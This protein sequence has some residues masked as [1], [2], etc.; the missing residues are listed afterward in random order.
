MEEILLLL[1]SNSVLCN[2]FSKLY[3]LYQ[4]QVDK[5]FKR[6]KVCENIIP[7]NAGM[8]ELADAS[9]LKSDD[10]SVVWVRV[11]FPAQS[12]KIKIFQI[13]TK[14]NWRKLSNTAK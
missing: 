2:R 10:H 4:K 11:P 6:N 7:Q 14:K 5:F 13:W 1:D 8:A 9:D 3:I 12:N